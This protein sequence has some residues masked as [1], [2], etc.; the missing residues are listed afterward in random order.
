MADIETRE[1]IEQLMETFYGKVLHN[2][3]IGFLFTEVAKLDLQKHLPIICDFWESALFQKVIYKGNVLG[4][5]EH[6]NNLHKLTENHFSA[7]LGLFNETVDELFK[8]NNAEQ[9]KI[10]ALSIAT[11]MR[12][13][14]VYK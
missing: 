7:W 12:S 2:E 9:I 11:V 13:K 5:H 4:V 6:L 10:R 14:I 8:G 1:D 3:E